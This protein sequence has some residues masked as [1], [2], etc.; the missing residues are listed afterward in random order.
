MG[1]WPFRLL[2]RRF[3]SFRKE[4]SP[5]GARRKDWKNNEVSIQHV[6]RL[7]DRAPLAVDGTLP[8]EENEGEGSAAVGEPDQPAFCAF[9]HF[10][11][12]AF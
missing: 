11:Q 3:V 4:P 5:Y 8:H 6:C 1:Q 7:S 12:R 9:R 10:A 2:A